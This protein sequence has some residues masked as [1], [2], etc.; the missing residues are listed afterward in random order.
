MQQIEVR[1]TNLHGSDMQDSCVRT[2]VNTHSSLHAL[3]RFMKIRALK[4]E[5]M[6]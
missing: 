5:M 6:N 3:S 4:V 2:V 1:L